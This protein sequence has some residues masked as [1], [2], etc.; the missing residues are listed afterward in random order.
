MDSK[1]LI[2]A[3]LAVTLFVVTIF[4]AILSMNGYLGSKKKQAASSVTV[5][6]DEEVAE[7]DGKIKGS[8]LNAWKYDETFFDEHLVGDGKY[9]NAE[10]SDQGEGEGGERKEAEG[11][12]RRGWLL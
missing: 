10:S 9:Q 7:K 4:I 1:V 6:S 3:L 8:D 12:R 11:R 2:K 5:A